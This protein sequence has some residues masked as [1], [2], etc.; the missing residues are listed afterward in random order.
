MLL[1][2]IIETKENSW[3]YESIFNLSKSTSEKKHPNKV[4]E[5]EINRPHTYR[6]I[7]IHIYAQYEVQSE[8]KRLHTV[9]MERLR[10]KMIKVDKICYASEWVCYIQGNQSFFGPLTEQK[11]VTLFLLNLSFL[12]QQNMGH[13][14]LS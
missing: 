11:N 13:H 4:K 2:Y 12:N 10:L 14:W 8:S 3:K 9:R 6:N 7:L 1:D 5:K